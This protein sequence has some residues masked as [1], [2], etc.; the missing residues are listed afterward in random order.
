MKSR[1]LFASFY[2][3][4]RNLVIANWAVE[5]LKYIIYAFIASQILPR[6]YDVM[7][8]ITIVRSHPTYDALQFYPLW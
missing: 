8:E 6:T 1:N 2:L 3:Y 5:L 7:D 4:F